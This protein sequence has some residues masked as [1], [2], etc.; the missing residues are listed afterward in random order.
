MCT[1]Y[2]V[3]FLLDHFD[4]KLGCFTMSKTTNT[5]MCGPDSITIISLYGFNL[6]T[7][8]GRKKSIHKSGK[9]NKAF[10]K[11][12]VLPQSQVQMQWDSALTNIMTTL[13][14]YKSIYITYSKKHFRRDDNF[15]V[16]FNFVCFFLC[17][18]I[19]PIRVE[20]TSYHA[21]L[22]CPTLGG[23]QSIMGVIEISLIQHH[24]FL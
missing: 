22:L 10:H 7:C 1:S 5:W 18:M 12:T 9:T 6:L 11:I 14:Q 24:H 15:V 19:L 4:V 21:S 13:Y 2:H 16:H 23:S 3:I 17:F 20:L 8:L